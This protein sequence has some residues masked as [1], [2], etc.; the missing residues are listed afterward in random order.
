MTPEFEWAG[1]NDPEDGS[2]AKR[3]HHIVQHHA[4]NTQAV[5]VVA[6]M[7]GFS[8]D[9][10]VERNQG[11]V[12]ARSGPDAI[13]NA[14]AN[15]AWHGKDGHLID[16]GNVGIAND[17]DDPLESAQEEL[18][19]R[20]AQSLIFTHHMLVIG[21][22]H[23]TAVGSFKG[24]HKFLEDQPHQR[25]AII[26]LDAHFDLRKPGKSGISSGTPFF[27]IH[28]TLEARGHALNYL[29]LGVA[30]T[31]N[32]KALFDRSKD[33]G[34]E[35]LLDQNVRSHLMEDVRRKIDAI[36]KDCDVLYL[37]IDLDVL[38]HWQMPAVSS[39]A[40]LGVELA[41]IEEIIDHLANKQAAGDISWPLSDIVEFNPNFDIDG[42]A[43]K[44]A[45]RLCDKVIRCMCN[46]SPDF[47]GRF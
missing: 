47:A 21:G 3:W 39:P 9:L 6:G 44:V 8:C 18:A 36:L 35:Y 46:D 28:Q 5:D 23:E 24:L 27:Q 22:G 12:G 32:T 43:A 20:V 17:G 29:C 1:R 16:F 7:I 10:G 4:L 30:E 19:D 25:I 31:S 38:P 13:R 40:P 37:S 15:L 11:R 2:N 42:H 41:V 45:A 33:W 26:N 34:V 14:L